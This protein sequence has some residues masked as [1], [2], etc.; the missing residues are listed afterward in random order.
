MRKKSWRETKYIFLSC[1]L[2][3]EE[4]KDVK[5]TRKT[6]AENK[7]YFPLIFWAPV[8][9]ICKRGKEDIE[10]LSFYPIFPPIINTFVPQV[11]I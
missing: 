5:N 2:V 7:S 1:C 8:G 10:Q 6:I 11:I 4:N 3:G 9:R